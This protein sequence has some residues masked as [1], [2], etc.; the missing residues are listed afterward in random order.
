GGIGDETDAANASG[1]LGH[2]YGADGA[3]SIQWLTTGNPLGFTYEKSGDNLLIKQGG[4][5]TVLTLTLNT[6]SGA[7][8]V[9][10]NAPIVHAAGLDENNQA[11][12]VGYRVTDGDGDTTDGTL[13]INVDDDTPTV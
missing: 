12:S 4:T 5:T 8:T 11:F 1:T 2:S 13:G 7:Y 6:T 10:Q 9:A 3:G